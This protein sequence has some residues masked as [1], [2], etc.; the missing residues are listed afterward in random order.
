VKPTVF[1]NSPAR[2][3]SRRKKSSAG[4]VDTDVQDGAEAIELANDTEFGLNRLRKLA[5]RKGPPCGA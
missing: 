3:V 5:D 4:P 1:A 2:C